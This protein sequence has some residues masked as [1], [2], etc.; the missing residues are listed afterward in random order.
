MGKT[1]KKGGGGVHTK[2][3]EEARYKKI[4]YEWKKK[5]KGCLHW[6]NNK[7]ENFKGRRSIKDLFH[8]LDLV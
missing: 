4:V 3:M 1:K 2:V 5:Q 8:F 7:K 6:S